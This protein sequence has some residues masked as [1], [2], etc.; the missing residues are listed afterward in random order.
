MSIHLKSLFK[1]CF[2][3]WSQAPIFLRNTTLFNQGILQKK[4][5]LKALFFIK[6]T[7]KKITNNCKQLIGFTKWMLY[8]SRY[9]THGLNLFWGRQRGGNTMIFNLQ[10]IK[11]KCYHKWLHNDQKKDITSIL[12]NILPL[13][14]CIHLTF[15]LCPILP[16]GPVKERFWCMTEG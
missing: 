1:V 10:F 12:I 9:D 2:K 5:T 3:R 16:D 8:K 6:I 13:S 14:L 11:W 7:M 15:L 4:W